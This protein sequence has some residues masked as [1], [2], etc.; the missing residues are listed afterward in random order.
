MILML[1]KTT[2]ESNFVHMYNG[3]GI[4]V[5][6]LVH[7]DLV[8][9]CEDLMSYSYITEYYVQL[10]ACMLMYQCYSYVPIITLMTY[11]AAIENWL[12]FG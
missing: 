5:G 8:L 10:Y 6:S 12:L 11:R 9:A 2:N 1:S 4:I 7:G 3:A